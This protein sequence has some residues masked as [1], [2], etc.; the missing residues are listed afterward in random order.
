[1]RLRMTGREMAEWFNGRAAGNRP[2]SFLDATQPQQAIDNQPVLILAIKGGRQCLI[3]VVEFMLIIHV[4][5]PHVHIDHLEFFIG[6]DDGVIAAVPDF[7]LF[8]TRSERKTGRI[9]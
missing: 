5:M 9:D 6:P 4:V 8:G 3:G 1:M 2:A 7:I